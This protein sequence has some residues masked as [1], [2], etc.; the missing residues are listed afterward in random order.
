M[1]LLLPTRNALCCLDCVCEVPVPVL[2]WDVLGNCN[3]RLHTISPTGT[4]NPQTT[5]PVGFYAM[6]YE[7]TPTVIAMTALGRISFSETALSASGRIS[8]SISH[9]SAHAVGPAN[10]LSVQL[11]GRQLQDA[12]SWASLSG[13]CDTPIGSLTG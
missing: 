5:N 7:N 3:M 12:G 9:D 11:S 10:S 1:T 2:L 6:Q 4:P 13:N 8:C